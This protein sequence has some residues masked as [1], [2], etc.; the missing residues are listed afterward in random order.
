MQEGIFG[1]GLV[2]LE[3]LFEHRLPFLEGGDLTEDLVHEFGVPFAQVSHVLRPVEEI[4]LQLADVLRQMVQ[5]VVAWT[6]FHFDRC[7]GI[8]KL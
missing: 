1:G 7:L 6:A 4:R 5:Q 8:R 2:L 3:F